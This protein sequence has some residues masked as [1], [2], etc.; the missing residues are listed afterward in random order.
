MPPSRVGILAGATHP[1][2]DMLASVRKPPCLHARV[3]VEQRALQLPTHG[4]GGAELNSTAPGCVYST[5]HGFEASVLITFARTP[6]RSA[7]EH[8]AQNKRAH[9]CNG[10][11]FRAAFHATSEGSA[12]LRLPS[13]RQASTRFWGQ[14]YSR[15]VLARNV[16]QHVRLPLNERVRKV[17]LRTHGHQFVVE[18]VPVAV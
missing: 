9:N 17:V 1:P 6:T 11:N 18:T 7:R 14:F 2:V 16:E 4:A 13:W 3:T 15:F 5:P 8:C 10:C 12:P